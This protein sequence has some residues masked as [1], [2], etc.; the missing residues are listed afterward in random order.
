[1]KAFL[2]LL[3]FA[4]AGQS[5]TTALIDQPPRS[6][7]VLSPLT[8][9]TAQS[10]QQL[11]GQINGTISQRAFQHRVL[12]LAVPAASLPFASDRPVIIRAR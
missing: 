7:M 5:Q 3:A 6:T 9:P 12:T 8:T 1:M 10:N 4:A 2:A 11:L